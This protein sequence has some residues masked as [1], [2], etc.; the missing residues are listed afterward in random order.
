M[1]CEADGGLVAQRPCPASVLAPNSVTTIRRNADEI[2]DVICDRAGVVGI[3]LLV[4]AASVRGL[5]RTAPN[6]MLRTYAAFLRSIPAEATLPLRY[7]PAFHKRRDE[8]LAPTHKECQPSERVRDLSVNCISYNTQHPPKHDGG[9]PEWLEAFHV[10][11][12]AIQ[13]SQNTAYTFSDGSLLPNLASK[14]AAAL[15]TVHG[16]AQLQARAISCGKATPYD[17][18]MFALAASIGSLTAPGAAEGA[19]HLHFFSDCRSAI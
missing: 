11:L 5:H 3:A 15:R 16:L 14:S 12:R 2:V 7:I 17:A 4:H 18:E 10:H 8:P 19:N 1:R 6:D 9:F 13:A